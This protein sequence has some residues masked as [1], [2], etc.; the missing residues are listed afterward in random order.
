MNILG[1]LLNNPPVSVLTSPEAADPTQLL[2]EEVVVHSFN[3]LDLSGNNIGDQGAFSIAAA[4]V[5]SDCS[6]QKVNLSCTALGPAGYNAVFQ[7]LCRRGSKV[8]DLDLSGSSG[9][10]A[11]Q[12]GA[13]G[14]RAL[15]QLLQQNDSVT[16]LNLH[17]VAFGTVAAGAVADLAGGLRA[18]RSLKSLDLS[19]CDLSPVD[20]KPFV[21]AFQA[22]PESLLEAKLE[23][24]MEPDHLQDDSHAFGAARPN[25]TFT[26]LEN[27]KVGTKRCPLSHLYLKGSRLKVILLYSSLCSC[28]SLSIYIYTISLSV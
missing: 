24:G 13:I 9:S 16:K 15:R 2:P 27:E 1:T 22:T 28:L 20:L 12:L 25:L 14:A 19:G 4:L 6:L 7:A 3:G 10:K 26:Y 17:K 23:G 8:I 11:M 21:S 5:R 18:N